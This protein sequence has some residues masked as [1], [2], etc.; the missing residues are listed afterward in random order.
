MELNEVC[1][2]LKVTPNQLAER[3][4]PPLSRQAVFYWKSTGIP[5]LRQYQIKEMLDD[6][7]RAD[8]SEV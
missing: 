8:T 4:D 5:K 1:E 3:F 7:E 2:K 6:S